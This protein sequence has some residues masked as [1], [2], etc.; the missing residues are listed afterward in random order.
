MAPV[1]RNTIQSVADFPQ[2]KRFQ[3]TGRYF[4]LKPPLRPSF[5]FFF[6]DGDRG[7]GAGAAETRVSSGKHGVSTPQEPFAENAAGGIKCI[8]YFTPRHRI[9]QVGVFRTPRTRNSW[10]PSVSGHSISPVSFRSTSS[11]NL[12]RL[13]SLLNGACAN[14]KEGV[15]FGV[16]EG[17]EVC[18]SLKRLLKSCEFLSG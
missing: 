1:L 12:K 10:A 16:K 5:L 8:D 9:G 2:L 14:L 4:Q 13:L 7:D 11:G 15:W 17:M 6:F 3:S 18:L